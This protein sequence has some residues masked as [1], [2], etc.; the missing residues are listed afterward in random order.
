MQGRDF[1]DIDVN[2]RLWSLIRTQLLSTVGFYNV[3]T[4]Y[5][6][7]T[8]IRL[9]PVDLNIYLVHFLWRIVLNK[10]ISYRHYV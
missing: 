3:F 8:K 10:E 4:K 6:V 2:V 5:D 1:D 9:E 7:L